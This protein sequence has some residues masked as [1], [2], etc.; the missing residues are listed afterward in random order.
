MVA[1]S[2]TYR[3]FTGAVLLSKATLNKSFANVCPIKAKT[4]RTKAALDHPLIR[5]AEE[6][7]FE[8]GSHSGVQV[9]IRTSSYSHVKGFSPWAAQWALQSVHICSLM[10]ALFMDILLLLLTGLYKP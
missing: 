1:E 10:G 4:I 2:C 8:R 6:V 9:E 5:D 7:I 3:V